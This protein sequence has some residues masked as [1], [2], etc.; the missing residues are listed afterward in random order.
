VA[1]IFRPPRIGGRGLGR[2]I[3][4]NLLTALSVEVLE[5][6]GGALLDFADVADLDRWLEK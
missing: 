4:E 1:L 2:F 3:K 6:L 5:K